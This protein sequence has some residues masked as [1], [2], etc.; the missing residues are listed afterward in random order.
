MKCLIVAAGPGARLQ[1]KGALK[2]LVP[3]LGIPLIERVIS[4]VHGAG[5][6]EFVVVSGYRGEELRA[7]LDAFAVREAVQM[8]HVINPEWRRANGVSLLAGG[9]ALDEPF[10]LTMCDHLVDPEIYRDLMA[11]THA[12]D[13]VTLGVDFNIDDPLNDPDDFTRVKCANGRILAIGKGLKDFNA[14]D[15]GVF[16]CTPA[17]FRAAQESQAHG[18]DSISGAITQLARRNAAY[19]FDVGPRVWIDVDDP[20]AYRKAEILLQSG[21]L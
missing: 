3:I 14:I 8:V 6:D 13:S 10:L 11:A 17:V 7:E 20:A 21:R 9:Q 5:V 4:A 1:E 2:P 18:D 19:V 16:L 12:A 15:T